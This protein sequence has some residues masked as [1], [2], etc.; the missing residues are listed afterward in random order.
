MFPTTPDPRRPLDV[1]VGIQWG[2]EGKGRVVDLL[3]RD[4]GVVARF[5]GGDNAGH[6]IEVGE[7][8]LA[9]HVVPSGVLVPGTRLLIGGGTVLSLRGLVDELDALAK[10]GVDV[11]RVAVSDRAHIV[12]PYHA[13]LDRL[14]EKRRG[15]G[16]IGTTGRGI[17]P[18]YVDRVGR[19]GI[20]FGDLAKPEV[21]ATKIRQALLLRAPLFA[22][23]EDVPREE[24]VV[25][26]T[27]AL[28]A[29]VVPHVVDGVAWLHEAMERGERILAEGAQGTMLDV[30]YGTYPYVTS[31]H[32]LAGG[33]CTGL[34]V[35][36]TAIGRVLGVAKAYCT[37]VGGG[38]FPSE[39][40][41]ERGERLRS[42]GRE[43]GVTTGRPRRCG[44]Y[45]A[46]AARYAAR[47]NGLDGLVI[48]K[49]DVLSGFERIGI[50]TG[51]RRADGTP[52]GI[53]AIGESDLRVEVEEH[54]GWSEDLRGVRRIA[55]LPAAARAFVARLSE[56]TG[57]P[58][59]AVS[60]GPERSA[61]A[62]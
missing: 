60:V 17:G 34:G 49:L 52:C 54:P 32:T 20:T 8:K 13:T 38:P 45:D 22:G 33:A 39:L 48:T 35:G 26:Q 46:V 15:G 19:L 50:V 53:E 40:E 5:G 11:S 59:I 29:R 42:A 12:F 4:Y 28:A 56:L 24:D 18:A 31:S 27:L 41:D 58:V 51:Y 7:T 61:L 16:A 25:G 36:P 9:L 1:C 14:N 21:L 43:F 47:L 37:R 55:D 30:T 44:W 57:A 10:L 2:D 3:A 23:A 6:S 62:I